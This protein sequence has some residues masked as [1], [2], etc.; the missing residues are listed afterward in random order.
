VIAVS[1]SR[2]A[3]PT[4]ANN[5]AGAGVVGATGGVEATEVVS[6][7]AGCE[8]V[9]SAV[10]GSVSSSA[11]SSGDVLTACDVTVESGSDVV[12]VRSDASSSALS[13]FDSCFAPA[14]SSTLSSAWSSS[15]SSFELS[16]VEVEVDAFDS[17]DD[18]AELVPPDSDAESDPELDE[19]E[20]ADDDSEPLEVPSSAAATPGVLAIAAPIPSATANA[21]TLPMKRP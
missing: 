19:S 12:G 5:A 10:S 8:T 13:R 7:F 9:A 15:S 16:D 3:E 6:A 20:L 17:V 18:P 14:S 11:G 2:R 4:I 21:P 1:V